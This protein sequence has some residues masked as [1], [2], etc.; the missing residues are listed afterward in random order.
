MKKPRVNPHPHTYWQALLKICI[1][2]KSFLNRT[3]KIKNKRVKKKD[4]NKKN[5]SCQKRISHY[6]FFLFLNIERNKNF[7]YNFPIDDI[8]HTDFACIPLIKYNT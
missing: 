8:M 7:L 6:I 3:I 4:F 5:L 2:S 1:F